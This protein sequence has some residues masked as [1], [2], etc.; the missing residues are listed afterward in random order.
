MHVSKAISICSASQSA[1]GE[2]PSS[3]RFYVR[4]PHCAALPHTVHFHF[5]FSVKN[6][7]LS[8]I[9]ITFVHV[10]Q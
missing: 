6:V 8:V 10:R 3:C 4:Q 9:I 1:C 7:T 5:F 2:W